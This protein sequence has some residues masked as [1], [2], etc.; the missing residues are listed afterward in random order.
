VHAKASWERK[1]LMSDPLQ[2]AEVPKLDAFDE[3]FGQH[4]TTAVRGRRRK[5]MVAIVAL[6]AG[7]IAALAFAWSSADRRLRLE[8]QSIT[9][10]ARTAVREGA[11]Q[12]VE[13]LRRRMDELEREARELRQARQQAN[14][15]IAALQAAQEEAGAQV[16]PPVD[17]YSNP[18]ALNPRIAN[19]PEPG[20]LALPSPRP[21]TPRRNARDVRGRLAPPRAP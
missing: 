6:C 1:L 7:A 4:S 2:A 11:E 9:A 8:P 3:E 20:S 17:W 16:P 12:E 13:R 21:S 19:E 5:I 14:D 18:A 15:T 10:S